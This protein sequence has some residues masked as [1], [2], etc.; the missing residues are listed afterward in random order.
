MFFLTTYIKRQ[1]L[2]LTPQFIENSAAKIII[3]IFH[4]SARL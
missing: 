1:L 2:L 3:V 4:K